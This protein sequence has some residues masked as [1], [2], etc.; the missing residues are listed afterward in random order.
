MTAPFKYFF[1]VRL[2]STSTK[3]ST[4]ISSTH[5][6]ILDILTIRHLGIRYSGTLLPHNI[7]EI[8]I[9]NSGIKQ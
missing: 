8:V 4:G 6:L 2:C 5:S 1:L 7:I 3:V 9:I